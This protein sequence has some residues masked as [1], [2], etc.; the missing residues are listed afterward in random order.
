MQGV[1]GEADAVSSAFP[2]GKQHGCFFGFLDITRSAF[3]KITQ[4]HCKERLLLLF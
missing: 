4:K 3:H 1:K 2:K